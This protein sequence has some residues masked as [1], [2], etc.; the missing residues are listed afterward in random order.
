L[1]YPPQEFDAPYVMPDGSEVEWNFE[2]IGEI[3][4]ILT[5]DSNG[6]DATSA[7]FDPDNIVQFGLNFQWARIRLMWTAF[8]PA[9]Y[10]NAETGEV[11]IPDSWRT[12]SAWIQDAVWT[13]HFMPNTTYDGSELLNSG[14]AFSSGNVAMAITPL[15]YTCCL[16]DAIGN[17]EFDLGVVPKGL[18]GKYNVGTDADT[19]RML[20]GGQNPE[21]AFTVLSYLLD[22]AVPV[23]A[24]TYG[25]FPARPEYQ[26]A[27][28]DSRNEQFDWGI[29]W[30]VPVASLAYAASPH[31]E[32]IV[33]NYNKAYEREF[34]FQTL[35]FGDTGA[36]IDTNAELDTLA[37]DLQAIIDEVQ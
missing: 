9:S 29:N 17:F 27:W 37:S 8:E 34:A 11:S 5:V 21:A 3:A 33:P 13:S 14:N 22:Q 25:A 16:G 26:Q 12:A 20:K 7:D 6:N 19:F 24:P 28:I 15:W 36:D 32:S 31:H 4:K 10:Y 30:D 2:T 23:L 35:L 1:N 18:N